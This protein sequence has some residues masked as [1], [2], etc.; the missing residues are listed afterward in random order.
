MAS[1]TLTRTTECA[2]QNHV[3]I[4]VTGD[5]SHVYRGDMVDLTAPI[6]ETEKDIFIKMI[7]RFAKIGRTNGQVRTALANGVTV[8]I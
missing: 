4:T 5:V 6:T 1:M 3:T 7:I 8:T 2:A